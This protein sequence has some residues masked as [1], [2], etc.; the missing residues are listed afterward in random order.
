M[1][2]SIPGGWARQKWEANLDVLRELR[3][4]FR[5]RRAI[6][7]ERETSSGELAAFM[8]P[9]LDSAYLGRAGRIAPLRW[10]LRAYWSVV[11][12]VLRAPP[13]HRTRTL[14]SPRS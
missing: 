2:V 13:P 8:T 9:D 7:S 4:T 14:P 12:W 1:V 11:C 3:P 5:E 6:Q 10:A